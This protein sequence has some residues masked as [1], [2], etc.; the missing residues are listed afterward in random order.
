MTVKGLHWIIVN[1]IWLDD[2]KSGCRMID[3]ISI[4]GRALS[5]LVD[6]RL[7]TDRITENLRCQIILIQIYDCFLC[8]IIVYCAG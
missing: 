1:N 6:K 5:K 3:W 7:H 2:V 4:S 8:C